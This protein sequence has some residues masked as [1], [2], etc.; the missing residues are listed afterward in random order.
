MFYFATSRPDKD[1]FIQISIPPGAYKIESLKNAIKIIITKEVLFGE[2]DCPF[3][4]TL[5]FS[6][7]GSI[8]K[9]S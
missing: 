5:K 7:L 1:R 6:T 8:S 9:I 2:T 4:I 3:T